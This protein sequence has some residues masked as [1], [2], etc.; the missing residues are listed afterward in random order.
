M[1]PSPPPPLKSGYLGIK[2][3]QCATKNDDRKISY[4]FILRL[5]AAHLLC[6]DGHFWEG[7][8]VHIRSW[9]KV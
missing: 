3:A 5:G 9:D 6:Q 1:Q 4:H 7:G 2:D 8:G